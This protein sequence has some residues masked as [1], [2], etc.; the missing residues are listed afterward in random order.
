MSD[1]LERFKGK[2]SLMTKHGVSTLVESCHNPVQHPPSQHARGTHNSRSL[3]GKL[4]LDR[5]RQHSNDYQ[6][7]RDPSPLK[8]KTSEEK[9]QLSGRSS[10]HHHT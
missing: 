10:S 9:H 8:A 2:T 7:S 1:F 6:Y 5:L 3:I 4:Q